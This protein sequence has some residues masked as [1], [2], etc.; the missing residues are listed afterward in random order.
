[1]SFFCFFVGLET[2]FFCLACWQATAAPTSM[3]VPR[4]M[5][6][7]LVGPPTSSVPLLVI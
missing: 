2:P 3:E 4:T 7:G 5:Q 1:L 6:R